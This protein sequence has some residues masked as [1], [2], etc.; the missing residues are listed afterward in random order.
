VGNYPGV[1]AE[2][3]EIHGRPHSLSLTL[4]PLSVIVLK[5]QR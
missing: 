5:P 3:R 1:M 2:N 4:P